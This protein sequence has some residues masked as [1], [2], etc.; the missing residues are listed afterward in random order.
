[1][2]DLHHIGQDFTHQLIVL[3]AIALLNSLID[4]CNSLC[5]SSL[6]FNLHKLQCIQKIPMFGAT[7][8]TKLA[9]ANPII[10]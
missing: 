10:K 6:S 5:S 1:M 7:N 8:H 3:V 4:Y 2:L 9:H